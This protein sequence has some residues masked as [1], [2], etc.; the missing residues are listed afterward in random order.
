MRPTKKITVI[1]FLCTAVF[2][3]IAGS[4]PP[5]NKQPKRNLKVLPKNISHDELDAI[6]DG[7]KAA[8]GVKCNFCH[9][10]S[11]DDP[12][13]MDFASDE[14]KEK[15]KAREMMRMTAKINQKFFHYKAS[16]DPEAK[17]VAPVSCITCHNGKK[18]PAN[19]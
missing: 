2:L 10:P 18:H 15:E 5:Q 3:G 8:L 13:K 16:K 14:K 12:R 17:T 6:M 1:I 4:K 9:S 19:Q 7:F 11:K